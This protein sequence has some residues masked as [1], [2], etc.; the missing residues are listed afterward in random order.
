MT[1]DTAILYPIA[2]DIHYAHGNRDATDFHLHALRDRARQ[3]GPRR[4]AVV[5]ADDE[6]ALTAADRALQLGIAVPVLIGNAGKIRAK[7][8]E[9]ALSSLLSKAELVDTADAAGEAVRIAREGT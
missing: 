3:L 8:A 2:D 5:V 4:L 6:V 1:H 9:L 7:A